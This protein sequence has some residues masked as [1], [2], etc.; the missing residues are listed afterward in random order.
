LLVK[1][2]KPDQFDE[3]LTKEGKKF[4]LFFGMKKKIVGFIAINKV[5]PKGGKDSFS[6]PIY[7]YEKR[8][9]NSV[10]DQIEK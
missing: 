8:K 1:S 2:L 7:F 3:Y 10:A 4:F 5:D 9:E 6:R